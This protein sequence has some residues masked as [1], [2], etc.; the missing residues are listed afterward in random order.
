MFLYLLYNYVYE[1]GIGDILLIK[2][3]FL[4]ISIVIN[5]GG[6][7]NEV[8]LCVEQNLEVPLSLQ[9]SITLA[10]GGHFLHDG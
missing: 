1:V 9:P 5:V 3:V 4:V 2:A 6:I 10:F 7:L 8:F